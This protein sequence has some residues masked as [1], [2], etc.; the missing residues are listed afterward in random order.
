MPRTFYITDV[1]NEGPYSGNQLATVADASGLSTEEMQKIAREFNFSETTFFM[2]RDS[3][4]GFSVRIFTPTDEL[5]FAGHPTLGTA[6]LIREHIAPMDVD[7]IELNLKVGK[8]PV[9]FHKNGVLW[10]KQRS[11]EFGDILD[12]QI[13]ADSLGLALDELDEDFPSQFVSTGLEFAMIPLVS[14]DALRRSAVRKSLGFGA[15][16]FC[17]DGYNSDQ[18]IAAR[19][20]AGSAGISEDPATGSANGCLASYLVE[21]GYFD[22]SSIDIRV[23][24]GYEINR[25]S[26]LHLRATKQ[27][28]EFDI[29]VGGRVGLVA[30]GELFC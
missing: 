20:Y 29:N 15:F 30:K 22:S 11:P 5:P 4:G 1:F 2:G 16:I 17:R 12:R 10:M 8:I 27:D 7:R 13:V 21:H 25:P 28:G 18:S 23:G 9:T 6:Y 14:M 19:M 3:D 24:Q 26:T